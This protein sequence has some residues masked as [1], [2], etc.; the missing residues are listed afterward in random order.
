MLKFRAGS[1]A[2]FIVALLVVPSRSI[3]DQSFTDDKVGVN[4][5]A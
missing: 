4:L 5:G 2:A 1:R 3:R